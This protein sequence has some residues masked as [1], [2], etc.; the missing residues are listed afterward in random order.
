MLAEF[1]G[2]PAATLGQVHDALLELATEVRQLR[3]SLEPSTSPLITG[4]DAMRQYR[5]LTTPRT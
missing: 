3:R 4:G 1:D 5:A 2:R